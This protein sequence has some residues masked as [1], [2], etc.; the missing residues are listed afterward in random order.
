MIWAGFVLGLIGS[1]H[2]LGMC[3]PIAFI[4]PGGTGSLLR[5]VGGRL[6]YNLGRTVTYAVM[7]LAFGFIGRTIS[8]AGYQQLVGIVVGSAM[9]LAV[10]LPTRFRTWLL[11][12][13]GAGPLM[14]WL[15]RAFGSLLRRGTPASLFMIG[16]CNGF[17]P[18]GLVYAALVSSVT[19]GTVM[20]GMFYMALFG[21]GTTPAMLAVS[22]AGQTFSIALRQKLARLLPI[23][24]IVLGLLF[25]LRGAS[26]GIP[27]LSPDTEHMLEHQHTP[28]HR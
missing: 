6:L 14:E 8:L 9:I 19:M 2:C 12:G 24:I 22:F 4:L 28:E 13:V 23:G 16:L 25:I 21:L 17:L 5:N 1:L 3:G 26:L 20:G 11:T 18:C 15:K 27:Y 7:G 10:I